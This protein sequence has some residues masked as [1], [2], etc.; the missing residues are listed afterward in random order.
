ML[1]TLLIIKLIRLKCCRIKSN[2]NIS[3]LFKKFVSHSVTKT[4]THR[5]GPETGIYFQIILF[6]SVF[7]PT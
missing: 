3:V 4:S 7:E 2:Q 6:K 1:I 5:Q